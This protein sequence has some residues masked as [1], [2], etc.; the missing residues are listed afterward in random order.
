MSQLNITQRIMNDYRAAR[1]L[2]RSEL[3]MSASNPQLYFQTYIAKTRR[4]PSSSA[5]K[6]GT[7]LEAFL[8]AGGLDGDIVIIPESVLSASGAKAGSKYKTWLS[9]VVLKNP[10]AVCLTQKQLDKEYG[11]FIDSH[12]NAMADPL[13]KLMLSFN[14]HE[15]WR[16]TCPTTGVVRKAELDLVDWKR[17]WV[18]DIKSSVKKT[19]EEFAFT[20][21][22][23]QYDVQASTYLEAASI[24]NNT[25]KSDWTFAWL[26]FTKSPP[27]DVYVCEATP[28]LIDVGEALN[29]AYLLDW[30]RRR[31]TGNWTTRYSGKATVISPRKFDRRIEQWKISPNEKQTLSY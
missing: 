16:W 28:E 13:A 10:S 15:A 6:Y 14:W 5:F 3:V 7:D 20:V 8:K 21:S 19:P 9:E 4:P 24:A 1:G 31:A 30:Q 22:D 12:R 18:V 29:E 17:K 26:V 27:Y 11:A 25:C 23:Y 2:S